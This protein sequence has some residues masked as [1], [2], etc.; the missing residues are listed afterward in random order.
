MPTFS[1]AVDAYL[2]GKRLGVVRLV[3]FAFASGTVRFALGR[4]IVTGGYTWTGAGDLIGISPLRMSSRPKAQQVTVTL[5]GDAP[6]IA[7]LITAHV[8]GGD[9]TTGRELRVLAQFVDVDD[10]WTLIESPFPLFIGQMR[11]LSFSISGPSQFSA[12]VQAENRWINRSRPRHGWL[13]HADQQRRHAGDMGLEF[14]PVVATD[15][16]VQWPPL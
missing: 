14:L 12:S 6:E 5:S 8:T 9:E 10:G 13:T 3:Q 1:A 15:L 11:T 7:E 2:A 16:K 4:T